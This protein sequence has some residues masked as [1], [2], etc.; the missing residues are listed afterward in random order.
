[1]GKHKSRLFS[2]FALNA[3]SQTQRDQAL[4]YEGN[5]ATLEQELASLKQ[6]AAYLA[7]TVP[8]VKP[9]PRIKTYVMDA[10]RTVEQVPA[11]VDESQC[12]HSATE[13]RALLYSHNELAG[14]MQ[15]VHRKSQKFFAP[16]VCRRVAAFADPRRSTAC[17]SPMCTQACRPGLLQRTLE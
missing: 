1:M 2:G 7:L 9:P 14:S 13:A 11:R 6:T 3:L 10:I 16:L 8:E 12:E 4:Q 15:S 5:A 17:R